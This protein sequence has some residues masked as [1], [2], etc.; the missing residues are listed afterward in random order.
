MFNNI[1]VQ[2]L[3][4]DRGVLAHARASSLSLSLSLGIKVV[5]YKIMWVLY[6]QTGHWTRDH[7]T[8]G[9]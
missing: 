2:S 6:V 8:T 4:D 7:R 1:K 3:K 5:V 9:K